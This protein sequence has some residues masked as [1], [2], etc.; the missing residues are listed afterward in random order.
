MKIAQHPET[1]GSAWFGAEVYR[2]QRGGDGGEL[3]RHGLTVAVGLFIGTARRRGCSHTCT[4][5]VVIMP[6][7]SLWFR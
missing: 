2:L 3:R 1:R 4:L 7:G 6:P 5:G